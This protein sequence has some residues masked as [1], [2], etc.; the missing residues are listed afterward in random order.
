MSARTVA[1]LVRVCGLARRGHQ[2]RT[3]RTRTPRPLPAPAQA[4]SPR[5]ALPTPAGRVA[6]PLPH[7]RLGGLKVAR[8]KTQKNA[9]MLVVVWGSGVLRR[10]SGEDPARLRESA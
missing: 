2:T 1:G 3:G 5:P 9:N 10:G 7:P 8:R 4:L 6:A